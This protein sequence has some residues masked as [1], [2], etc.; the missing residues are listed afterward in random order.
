MQTRML[1]DEFSDLPVQVRHFLEA[2]CDWFF[3]ADR[4]FHIRSC[5]KSRDA[6]YEILPENL[7]GKHFSLFLPPASNE[8]VM[9]R[10]HPGNLLPGRSVEI[11][12]ADPIAG[13]YSL[14]AVPQYDGGTFSGCM[15]AVR[16]IAHESPEPFA[17][18]PGA[19][20]DY[21]A[22]RLRRQQLITTITT[23][24]ARKSDV[25][26]LFCYAVRTLGSFM[27]V[28]R[29]SVFSH[30]AENKTY[31]V[32]YEW[33]APG[34]P[35]TK[36]LLQNI[37]YNDE[38]EGFIQLTT[39]PYIAVDDTFQYSGEAYRVQ[40]ENGVRSFVDIPLVV[41]GRFWGFIGADYGNRAHKWTESEFHML[42]GIAGIMSSLLE[43]KRM[44][45]RLE[46]AIRA[47]NRAN[48]AKSEFL[49]R[50]SHEIRTPMNAIIG[51]NEIAKKS[52]DPARMRY[53]LEKVESAAQQLLSLINDVLDLSKIEANKLEIVNAPF[54]FEGML[55][56]LYH[57]V[58]ARVEEKKLEFTFDLTGMPDRHVVSD[59]LRLTQIVTNFLSNAV[60]FTP[61]GGRVVLHAHFRAE[62]D[63]R[64]L[65][66]VAV[67][68]TGIGIS[69]EDRKKL[70]QSFE[71][72]DS[73]VAHRFGGTG[74]GLAIC[75]KL[76]DLMGGDIQVESEPGKGSCFTFEIPVWLGAPL[77]PATERPKQAGS[78]RVLLV[79]ED[80]DTLAA[81]RRMLEHFQM[82]CDAAG[83]ADTAL[84]L[85]GRAAGERAPYDAVFWGCRAQ[86]GE[87]ARTFERIRR[88]CAPDRVI[89]MSP[90]SEWPDIEERAATAGFVRHL[91]KPV[92]PSFLL[93]AIVERAGT[94][95]KRAGGPTDEARHD[96]RGKRVLV[97]EDIEL[98]QEILCS[99]LE[100]TGVEID[101]KDDG[102]AAVAAF[103]GAE[104]AYDLILM[105][106][107]MPRMDGIEATRR[108]RACGREDARTVPILA[109][110]ANAFAEDVDRC[111]AAG[112]NG[113][114]AKP[115]DVKD[116]MEKLDRFL[117]Q[118]RREE[119]VPK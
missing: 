36:D 93:D 54:D 31:S 90:S 19:A 83:D 78:V 5:H 8:R 6:I 13:T 28:D 11:A 103:E 115:I 49:S 67:R 34:V 112:M 110:T 42:L 7:I 108:I 86:D 37:P 104:S 4:D 101:C 24:F 68:D 56:S 72:A 77:A 63:E 114:V 62:D 116:L 21:A 105:D 74:L 92:L 80:Q 57:V 17:P 26:D 106:M 14:K 81:C 48:Q 111:L 117:T 52:D 41:E 64:T 107:Q 61:E 96:W 3:I 46:E 66:R 75:K 70:F 51:M 91:A 82:S 98:N 118:A 16:R 94:T 79:D 50:M 73:S 2:A 87:L 32:R 84:D 33:C 102:D 58:Q 89:L 85:L 22:E 99:L 100:P 97:A 20:D 15:I 71:Q 55:Q 23:E 44:Q 10:L 109:M 76:A 65:L 43:K 53:C 35:S 29:C 25:D 113:H 59:R 45:D 119:R 47:A 40:R 9:A 12:C 18:Q 69:E 38:D 95:V 60:K 88:C 30:D 27:A 39:R 1:E